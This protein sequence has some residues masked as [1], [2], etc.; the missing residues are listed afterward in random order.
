MVYFWAF[1]GERDRAGVSLHWIDERIDTGELISRRV[2]HILPGMTQD[3]VLK[4][5]ATIGAKLLKRAG[6]LLAN[7]KELPTITIDPS[8]EDNYYPL[9]GEKNFDDYF[10]QNRFF[11]IRDILGFALKKR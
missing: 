1:L 6:N 7:G 10:K 5:T 9:P 8:E 2:F 11:R 3:H 4:I